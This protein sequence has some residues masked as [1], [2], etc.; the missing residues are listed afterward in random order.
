M[1]LRQQ[2]EE[3]NR[4]VDVISTRYSTWVQWAEYAYNNWQNASERGRAEYNVFYTKPEYATI[5]VGAAVGE[6]LGVL[7]QARPALNGRTESLQRYISA[8]RA[9]TEV[10]DRAI[11]NAI[12][13]QDYQLVRLDAAT[14]AAALSQ[15]FYEVYTEIMRSNPAAGAL[16]H[17]MRLSSVYNRLMMAPVP[18]GGAAQ[19]SAAGQQAEGTMAPPQWLLG[20]YQPQSRRA[21]LATGIRQ[22]L[23]VTM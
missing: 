2:V 19:S 9:A 23:A 14:S 6:I 20:R 5:T 1:S 10:C 11:R 7:R 8:T 17:D 3:V 13:V 18:V 21:I 22:R 15:D 12:S 4:V 16:H